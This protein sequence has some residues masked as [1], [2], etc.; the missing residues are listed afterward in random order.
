MAK[1]IVSAKFK[2]N[3]HVVLDKY[4][5]ISQNYTLLAAHI[6]QKS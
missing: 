5:S 4:V 1:Y 3:N 6:F 2:I